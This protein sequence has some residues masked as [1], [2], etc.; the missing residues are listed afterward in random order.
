MPEPTAKIACDHVWKVFGPDP[1]R[2][3]SEHGGSPT[4]EDIA[5]TGH[6]AAVRD[7]SISVRASEIF[8]VMG[9]SGSGKSTLVRC[10]A[11]LIEPTSG[12]ISVDDHDLLAL[13][14]RELTEFRRRRMAMVFQHFALLP[15][16][17][18][19]GNVAFP[20]EIRGLGRAEREQRALEM[21]E[22]VGLKGRESYY[23]RELS[24]GQQ[25]RVGI[26]RALT[27]D[28]EL[29][30]LDEPFSALDPLIRREMQD[31]LLRLQRGLRK[32][33][34]FITHDFDEA[35]KLADR[36]AVMRDGAIIQVG[37]PEE[38]VVAPATDYVREFTRDVPRAKV[39]TSRSLMR[40]LAATAHPRLEVA[41]ADRIDVVAPRLIDAETDATVVDER[42]EPVG[43]LTRRRVLEALMNRA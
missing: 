37:T 40:P 43:L 41:A 1:R 3:L 17:T 27:I 21:I 39:L 5:R 36:I 16:D 18:V 9:L 10:M 32:T 35:I 14:D 22:L 19:L 2:L 8:V 20:L 34:V 11:R 6:V 30:F 23:P 31:E 7:V 26:A 13:D 12:G 33:I 29:L 15:H 38:V 24:G 4:T 28:P 42:G 25:Q